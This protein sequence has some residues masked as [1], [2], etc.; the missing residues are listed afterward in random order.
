MSLEDINGV[1]LIADPLGF[2][3]EQLLVKD[4]VSL[5]TQGELALKLGSR[6]MPTCSAP[7]FLAQCWGC[8]LRIASNSHGG[9]LRA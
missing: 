8:R 7:N 4:A 6:R 5:D 1:R 2:R 9:S 3:D